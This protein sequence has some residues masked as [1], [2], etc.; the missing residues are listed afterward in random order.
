MAQS[1][2]S[3][4]RVFEKRYSVSHEQLEKFKHYVQ[5]LQTWREFGNITA[6][7][8]EQSIVELHFEDSLA[9]THHQD[10][11]HVHAIAD[12]GSGGGFPGIPLAIIYPHLTV[13]LIEV[14]HKKIAFLEQLVNQL[15]LSQVVIVPLDWRTFLRKTNHP[16]DIFCARASLAITELIRMF[17]PSCLYN[18]STLFYW[19]SHDW[20]APKHA[21]PYI[22]QEWSYFVG[23]R[24]RRIITLQK[25]TTNQNG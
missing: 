25:D 8:D 17:K 4:W 19:A 12:I 2:S 11:S 18:K 21:Q 15:G 22:K 20:Q 3:I 13:Y 16:I 9:V 24:N 6:L 14:K 10:F 7:T 23:G 1:I 5:A